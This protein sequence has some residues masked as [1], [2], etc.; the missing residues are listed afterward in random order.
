MLRIMF[1][2]FAGLVIALS[3]RAEA[4]TEPRFALVIGNSAY[5]QTGWALENPARD[6]ALVANALSSV[7]FKV[8]TVIDATEAQMEDAFAAHG[9]RLKAAG[10]SAVGLI[11]YAGHGVQSQGLNYLVPVDSSARSEQD[12]WR[13][14]PR[15]GDALR[16]VEDAG[17]SVNFVIL[18]ACRN[19]PLP[20]STRSAGGGLAEV[21]PAA[22][23]L[24]S[25]ST[26][27]GYVAYDGEGGNSAFATA[28]AETLSTRNLIAEQVFKRVA[29]RVRQSTNGLQNPFYNSGL[30][31]AD[32]C[33]AGCNGGPT[34]AP[35][36][37]SA[38]GRLPNIASASRS[39]AE[40]QAP[41][42]GLK[43]GFTAVS[44]LL[45]D[46]SF[47]AAAVG[48]G[49]SERT[50]KDCLDCPEMIALPAGTFT[51]GSPETEVDRK[52]G[53]GPQW[54]VNVD[55]FAVSATEITWAN[56]KAC[57][58]GGGCADIKADAETR[59]EQWLQPAFP[60]V[61][62]TW[63]EAQS[64]IAW[65]NTQV[66]GEPYRLLS[67]AEW[68]YAARAGTQTA[69]YTGDALP[70]DAANFNATRVYNGS[71]KGGW[72]RTLMP[73]RTY[74]PNPFGLYEMHGNAAEWV[75][76]CWYSNYLGRTGDASAQQKSNCRTHGVR[77]GSW[78][79]IPSY[80][81]SAY[82]DA[83]PDTGR[84]DGIGFRVARSQN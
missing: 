77:G 37:A 39:T 52:D 64:Y 78:E 53:E 24:I 59:S 21:K 66:T 47:A 73:A 31:G 81:R 50:F 1:L 13:Q 56:V 54:R 8:D 22:G 30:T 29:D 11:Y 69:F 42:P 48:S 70:G 67:E 46:T 35:V 20:S 83:Y 3:S 19:N 63:P 71:P 17:N 49:I 75:E 41:T 44:D 33:F 12:I 2:A 68:E 72:P 6:A 55:T 40:T 26:A 62:I 7:G 80:V 65:L 14:A 23:L 25:Y 74:A 5:R 43:T 60:V 9:A 16:Y 15:L 34:P 51:M 38:G 57:R 32:F 61:N 79:K 10:P 4:P 58:D 18:D 84:S 45:R 76:D 28:L 82:R 36:A 27:P